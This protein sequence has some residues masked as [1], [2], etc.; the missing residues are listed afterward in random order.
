MHLGAVGL[1]AYA[2]KG[3]YEELHKILGPSDEATRLVEHGEQ[4]LQ[5]CGVDAKNEILR[6]WYELSPPLYEFSEGKNE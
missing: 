4:E 3:V 1:P 6:R 2:F 5:V